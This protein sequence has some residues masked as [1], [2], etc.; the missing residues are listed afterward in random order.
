MMVALTTNANV[1]MIATAIAET[2]A[3]EG[4]A[5]ITTGL[6]TM[7]TAIVDSTMSVSTAE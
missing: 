3:D 5:L 6:V 2:I 1:M 4:T 7:M